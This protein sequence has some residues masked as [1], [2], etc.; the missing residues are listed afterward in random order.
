MGNKSLGIENVPVVI[1]AGGFGTRL[2]EETGVIP[3]PMVSIGEKPILWHIMKIYSHYGCRKFIICLGYRG[4]VIK[5]YFVH[6]K[7]INS[8]FTLNLSGRENIVTYASPQKEDWQVT[9]ADT[10]IEAM[11]GFR[12]KQI[13]KYIDTDI[14]FLTYGDGLADIRIDELFEFHKSHGRTATVTGVYPPSRFGELVAEGN[15]VT[16][17]NEKSQ[18]GTGLING[19]FFVFSRNVFSYLNEE[20]ECTLERE[21]LEKMAGDSQLKIYRHSGFWQCLDTPRDKKLLNEYC[22]GGNFPWKVWK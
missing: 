19:G 15:S 18:V 17:F 20:K 12:V 5:E 7:F 10:G 8:D 22:K 14:F 11:T 1:L 3:K 6:Y 16:K 2:G 13:E 21:P 9:F 4:E